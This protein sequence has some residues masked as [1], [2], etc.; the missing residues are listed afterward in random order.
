ML[1]IQRAAGAKVPIN[2]IFFRLKRL[3][4]TTLVLLYTYI[5]TG[6]YQ[7]VT[8]AKP[9]NLQGWQPVDELY[10]AVLGESCLG[11]I[12]SPALVTE[13][14]LKASGDSNQ[15]DAQNGYR[16]AYAKIWGK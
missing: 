14:G 9:L 13:E 16:D 7:T 5:R 4:T 2:S 10:R 11:N 1:G 8:V 6:Q 3:S 15:F 12:T